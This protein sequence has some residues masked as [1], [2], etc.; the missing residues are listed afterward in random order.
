MSV[1]VLRGWVRN[2]LSTFLILVAQ[3]YMQRY[4]VIPNFLSSE[5][6]EALLKRS[7][8]LLD[9][10]NIEEHPFVI[11]C[12]PEYEGTSLMVCWPFLDQIHNK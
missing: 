7:K 10:F 2:G 12:F 9:E 1:V 3:I 6:T 11:I 4:L 8:Q 5:D